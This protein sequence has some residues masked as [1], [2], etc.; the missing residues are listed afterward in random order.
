MAVKLPLRKKA[1]LTPRLG[2]GLRSLSRLRCQR[3]RVEVASATGRDGLSCNR[4]RQHLEPL[5]ASDAMLLQLPPA[6]ETGGAAR[7]AR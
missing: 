3:V 7:R 5:G 2:L 6:P 4:R 1:L